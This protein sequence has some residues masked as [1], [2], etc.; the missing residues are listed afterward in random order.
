MI[1]KTANGK[2]ELVCDECG[3]VHDSFDTYQEAYE[4]GEEMGWTVFMGGKNLDSCE[5]CDEKRSEVE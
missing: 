4:Y 3:R 1:G 2:F 5:D